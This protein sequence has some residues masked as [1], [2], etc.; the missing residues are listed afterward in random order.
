[1]SHKATGVIGLILLVQIFGACTI[2]GMQQSAATPASVQV[3]T[4]SLLVR[5][6]P[7]ATPA[8]CTDTF[9]THTLDHTTTT[10]DGIIRQ[11]DANGAGLAINDL[12]NDGDLDLVLGSYSEPNTILWNEGGLNFRKTTF[13]Q[14]PTRAITVVDVDADGWRDIVLTLNTGA[15]NYWRNT[16]GNFEKMVLPGVAKAAYALNWGDLDSDGDLDLVTASYDAGFLSDLGNSYLLNQGGGVIYYEN[17]DGRFYPTLLASEAQA[18]AV[19]LF[20]INHDQR[21]DIW[22]GNDFA[23]RDQAWVQTDGGW[24]AATPFV[25]TT[26]STMSLDQGDVNNDGVAEFFA[27][28]MKPYAAEDMAAWEPMMLDMMAEEHTVDDP[29]VMEN[30]LQTRDDQ[31]RY[32][33][34]AASLGI[35]G[36]GWSWAARFGDLDNDGYLDLYIVNGMIEEK[37]FGHLPNHELVEENQAF[38]NEDGWR[39]TAMPQWQLNSTASGRSMGMA[40]L[41]A[42]GDL[43][44]V[45]NNLRSPAQLFENQLCGGDN[46]QVELDWPQSQNRQAIGAQLILHT[47]TGIYTRDVRAASGYLTGDPPRVHFGFPAA[48]QLVKLEVRWPDRTITSLEKIDANLLLHLAR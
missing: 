22:I 24:T 42:D 43:E 18:L 12:D 11:F 38:R 14:G 48:A 37:I 16:G 44:I 33:N 36:T 13:G 17:R 32:F 7:L 39:F 6:T 15:L 45:V 2:P 9:V 34:L 47:S 31:G 26:H 28:D 27:S 21:L 30:V 10:I 5:K 8:D 3:Q 46:L 41:D 40:D 20:D 4:A 35:N 23:V 25:N 19:A 29:Q 1:M